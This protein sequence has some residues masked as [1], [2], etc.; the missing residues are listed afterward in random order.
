[1]YK[2]ARQ[3]CI[4]INVNY[5]STLCIMIN[6]NYPCTLCKIF[7]VGCLLLYVIKIKV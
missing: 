6:V 1:M 3:L 4:M 2:Y 7:L 5:S